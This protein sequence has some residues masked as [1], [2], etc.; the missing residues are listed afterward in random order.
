MGRFS[1]TV[2]IRVSETDDVARMMMMMIPRHA[3]E[4]DRLRAGDLRGENFSIFHS[5]LFRENANLVLGDPARLAWHFH[6]STSQSESPVN[7]EHE[8][9]PD[10]EQKRVLPRVL[11]EEFKT[12][13]KVGSA[14]SL[15]LRAPP[16]RRGSSRIVESA[17]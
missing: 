7:V 14:G 15:C 1:R 16:S 8:H 5:R 11:E 9:Q 13:L 3:D 2:M 10:N 6:N 4:I 12:N 17:P